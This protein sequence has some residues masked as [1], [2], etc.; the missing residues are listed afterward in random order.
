MPQGWRDEDARGLMDYLMRANRQM[1]ILFCDAAGVITGWN[2]AAAEL[3]GYTHEEAIGQSASMVFTPEDRGQG[4]DAQELAVA[5]TVGAAEDERWHLRR[6]GS[7]FWSTGLLFAVR[8]ADGLNTGF[9]KVFRDATHLRTRMAYLEN[10]IAQHALRESERR[11]FIG[12]VAH[13]LR[14]PLG[15]IRSAVALLKA[16]PGPASERP[17]N[18]LDR[19][20]GLMERLVEDLVDLTRVEAGKFNIDYARFPV[21]PLLEECLQA[22]QPRA[23]DKGVVLNGVLPPVPLELEA[24][25]ARLQQVVANLLNNAIKFTPPGGHVWLGCTADPTHCIVFVKDTGQG[26]DRSL[27]PV[28]FEAFTQAPGARSDRGAGLGIGL[29]VARAIVNLHGGTIEAR[30]EGPGKGSEFTV[31][32]PLQRRDANQPFVHRE[33]GP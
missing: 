32:I 33:G 7:R 5:R 21:Q 2:R 28:I 17:L 14:N 22:W 26:M 12:R 30:S 20:T 1:A 31:R 4:L 19:Q 11:Q 3:T 16:S 15:P 8:S 24:D 10:V 13:E 9:V 18:I 23:D 27:M 25:A 29:S 6:D